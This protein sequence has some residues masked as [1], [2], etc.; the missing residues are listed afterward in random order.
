MFPVSLKATPSSHQSPL[1][2]S[3]VWLP[4]PS[5]ETPAQPAAQAAPYKSH[6]RVR[7]GFSL[8][9]WR[10]AGICGSEHPRCR[11]CSSLAQPKPHSVHHLFPG[12]GQQ[13]P[14]QDTSET[15][16]TTMKRAG[17]SRERKRGGNRAGKGRED[18]FR[19]PNPKLSF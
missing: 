9:G 13:G 8:P 18:H 7:Q 2:P 1:A 16:A 3:S 15:A 4:T 11:P 6:P 5:P 10:V 19:S 12:R 14:A 17:V